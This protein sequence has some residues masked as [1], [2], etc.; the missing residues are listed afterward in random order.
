MSELVEQQPAVPGYSVGAPGTGLEP[1][2]DDSL[3]PLG[4]PGP[5]AMPA[6]GT[7]RSKSPGRLVLAVIA[8]STIAAIAIGAAAFGGGSGTGSS[9][10]AEPGPG[11]ASARGSLASSAA[12]S[13]ASSSVTFSV[14]ATQSTSSS[15]TSLL[16]GHG[17][18]DLSGGIGRVSASVPGLSPLLGGGASA[19]VDVVSDGTNV[20]LD[21][22]GISSLTGGKS[23]VETP[24]S[25][26][27]PLTGSSAD[28]LALSALADPTKALDMLGSVGSPVTKVGIVRLNGEPTTEYRT[29][30]SVAAVASKLAQGSSSTGAGAA[31]KALQQLG[32]PSVPLTA[33]VGGDGL[34]RQLSIRVD[35][36]HASLAGLL[37]PLG[38]ASPS[39]PAV[40]TTVEV[41]VGL[42]HYGL[43][44]SVSV[45]PAS[46]VTNLNDLA[47]S[48]KG[49]ASQLGGTLSGLASHV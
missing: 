12:V 39:H 47:P 14:S 49:L 5:P 11:S 20:Y 17:S 37:G 27:G 18:V 31:A 16:S 13:A 45:P 28:S 9:G 1:R 3:V 21:L 42:S 44:V 19:S 38:V 10:V 4:P 6:P 22:P 40:G 48:L 46:E 7:A 33:W 30:I 25:A 43:P 32:V 24:L 15:T 2:P 35:L 8:V 23:W 34:L 41:T 26:L 29:T 36:S